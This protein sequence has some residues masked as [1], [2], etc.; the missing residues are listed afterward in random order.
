MYTDLYL[1]FVDEVQA[2]SL[3]YTEVPIAYDEEGNPIEFYA[4]PNYQNIDT[5]GIMYTT[6][7]WDAEGNVIVEPVPY[8]GWH[9]NVRALPDEDISPLVAFKVEPVV[10]RRVWG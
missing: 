5:L 1:K 3:L 7:E 6:G 2:I 8:D 10:P 9:V 4:Q